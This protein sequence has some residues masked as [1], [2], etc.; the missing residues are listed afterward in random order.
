MSQG[1]EAFQ[2]KQFIRKLLRLAQV[3]H[4]DVFYDLGCGVGQ[5]CITAVEEFDVRKAVGIEIHKGRAKKARVRVSSLGLNERVEIRIQDIWDSNLR[6]PTI[7]YYG[8]TEIEEDVED[9]GRKLSPGCRLVTLHLPLL[10]VLPKAIDYPF[11]MMQLPFDVT[12][13]LAAWT[14]AVFSRPLTREGLLEE[15]DSDHFYGYDKRTF[16]RLLSLRMDESP[17]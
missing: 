9:F 12:R 17:K 16:K 14:E 8:L 15:L 7:A 1:P 10:G 2:S 4:N 6:E 3:S 13:N 11:F 5:L